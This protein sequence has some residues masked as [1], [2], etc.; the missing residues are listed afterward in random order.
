M[1]G[2]SALDYCSLAAT[3]LQRQGV[4]EVLI[5]ALDAFAF[6][7]CS[8]NEGQRMHPLSNLLQ[9][10]RAVVNRIERSD[11]GQQYLCSTD[12]GVGFLAADMLFAGLQSHA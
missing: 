9:A 7:A 6:K 5:E 10:L 3:H 8:Q 4:E 1:R 11:V 2:L 12:V